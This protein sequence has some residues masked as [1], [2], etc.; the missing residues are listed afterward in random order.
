MAPAADEHAGE[1]RVAWT[2]HER[3]E[4]VAVLAEGVLDEAVVGRVL[5][6]GEQRAVQPHPA[7]LV[8]DLVLVPAP[9]GDLD[10]YVEFH[11]SSS[12]FRGGSGDRPSGD[13]RL[14][15]FCPIVTGPRARTAGL[16][17]L[18]VV[19]ALLLGGGGY[20]LT[21]V[22]RAPQ[23]AP[24]ASRSPLPDVAGPA[25]RPPT[26]AMSSSSRGDEPTPAGV[27]GLSA[28]CSR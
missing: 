1:Q 3:V 20:L 18:V 11:G 28:R 9:P 10:E 17:A 25:V 16:T 24:T 22:L 14:R 5:R 12:S 27:A 21:R 7:G 4:R 13:K 6:R 8:I 19:V 2:E 23:P 26:A 15:I